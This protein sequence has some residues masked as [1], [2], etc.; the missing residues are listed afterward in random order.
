MVICILEKNFTFTNHAPVYFLPGSLSNLFL[1][2][3]LPFTDSSFLIEMEI[4]ALRCLPNVF[5]MHTFVIE[6]PS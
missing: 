2:A 1:D 6:M 4:L 3:F 5:E